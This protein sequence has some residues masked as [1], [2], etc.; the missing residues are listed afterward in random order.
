MFEKSYKFLLSVVVSLLVFL[1]FVYLA[2]RLI[3][4]L[5]RLDRGPGAHGLERIPLLRGIIWL[6]KGLLSLLGYEGK[7]LVEF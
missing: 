5:C 7:P 3:K 2:W 4:Y 6:A 1:L